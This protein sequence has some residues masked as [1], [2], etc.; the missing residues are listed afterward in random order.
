M[1]IDLPVLPSVPSSLPLYRGRPIGPTI[2]RPGSENLIQ[3]DI[4]F[5][6][7]DLL[8]VAVFHPRPIRVEIEGWPA[9]DVGNGYGGFSST[10]FIRAGNCTGC[11]GCCAYRRTWWWDSRDPHPTDQ[12]TR[13]IDVRINGD[14]HHF[15]YHTT[16]S[17]DRFNVC[18]YLTP[19]YDD[20][21]NQLIDV[22]GNEVWHC[23]LHSEVPDQN[24]K[25]HHCKIEPFLS[26]KKVRTSFG[27]RY[28]WSRRLP[29]RNWAWPKCPSDVYN[30]PI[31]PK[32]IEE[33]RRNFWQLF[34][35]YG[36]L[37]NSHMAKGIELWE[38]EHRLIADGKTPVNLLFETVW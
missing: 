5:L 35:T 23:K 22:A 37:P 17:G 14:K 27:M 18:D 38:R 30:T 12:S 29:S 4:D 24:I 32:H 13:P 2:Y 7:A 11:G 10:S 20:E 21:L 26:I 25:P 16:R 15:L 28:L 8:T 19:A 31:E 36:D 6:A 9:F 3:E 34:K 1:A 33:D